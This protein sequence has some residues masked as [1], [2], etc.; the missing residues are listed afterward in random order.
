MQY[1]LVSIANSSSSLVFPGPEKIIF[2]GE[3]PAANA[4]FISPIDATSI[5]VP[6]KQN[7][8]AIETFEFA[9]KE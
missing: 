2:F 9:F 7:K 4:I 3:K 5:P 6:H 1:T 8:L